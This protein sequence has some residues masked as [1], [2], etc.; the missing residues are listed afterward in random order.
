MAQAVTF[1]RICEA[2]CGMVAEVE[3]GRVTSL[4]PDRDHPLSKGYACPKGIA[5]LDV[6]N[7]PERVIHPLARR[8]DGTFARTTWDQAVADIGERLKAIPRERIAWYMGNPSAFS[9]SHSLWT[10]GFMDALGSRHYYTAGSQDVNNRFAASAL[11]YDSPVLVPIPDLPRT[12]LLLMIGANPLV[13]HGSLLTTPRIREALRDIVARGG[14][15]VVVDP[16]RT[17]TA[18][19]FEHLP[20]RPDTDALLLLSLL[21][22]VFDEGLETPI[23]HAKDVDTLRGWAAGF[24]PEDTAARTGVPARAARRLARDL[25]EADGAAVY[26][27]TGSCLGRYGTLVAFLLDALN[28]VTGNLDV[29]G[30][31]VFGSPPI[32]L[33]ELA[34]RFGLATYDTYRR[35]GFPEVLGSLPASLMAAE[36]HDGEI[37]AL[38]TS[39]GNPV[40]SVP[41]GNALTAALQDL[42]LHVSLDFYV[43]ETNRHADY[44]L[45]ST[46]FLERDDIPIAS[47]SFYTTP[48]IQHT[49]PV[50]APAGEA[51]EEWEAIE[52]ISRALGIVPS[53]LAPARWAGRLGIRPSP[54]RLIDLLL[55]LATRNRL[56]VAKLRRHPHGIVLA[57]HVKTGVLKRKVRLGPPEIGAEIER[58]GRDAPD[59]DFPLRLIG[60]RELRSHNSWMHRPPKLAKT[61]ALRIHPDD[62]PG[63][64]DGDAVEIASKDGAVT[65]AVRITDEMMPGVVALPHGWPQANSNLLASS[66]PEDLEPLAGMAFLNGIAVRVRPVAPAPAEAGRSSR[67]QTAP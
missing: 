24:A 20:V 23:R 50:V 41:N 47:L 39:A 52:L 38:I 35:R 45:P 13:S 33:D 58:L 34:S 11:L 22:T 30:G 6:Q 59:P 49:D 48:F 3:N 67:L 26:G 25:A 64:Q 18:A 53:S 51:K 63:L 4:R 14:R 65:V 31:A 9:Y 43:N 57:E 54:Q 55:R 46:T 27:R 19:A 7:D 1:C 61:H 32:P 56:S 16:R 37:R 62:A 5:M 28:A 66:A 40:L 12:D 10:K 60:L 17:E 8:P 2:Y 29:P 21:H 42:D 44:I 36:M 15:V